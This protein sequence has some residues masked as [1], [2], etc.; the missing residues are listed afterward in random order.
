M[1][2]P[3]TGYW[4]GKKMCAETATT[5]SLLVTATGSNVSIVR[6]RYRVQTTHTCG[7][8]Q[9]RYQGVLALKL[10]TC[11]VSIRTTKNFILC[12][13]GRPRGYLTT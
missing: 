3:A 9:V 12:G 13:I 1:V 2:V 8:A 7:W 4:G 5:V 6:D 10:L 11:L